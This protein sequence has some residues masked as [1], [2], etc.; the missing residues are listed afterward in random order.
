MLIER[1]LLLPEQVLNITFISKVEKIL[2]GSLDLTHHLKGV[3]NISFYFYFFPQNTAS[4]IF[5]TLLKYM[6]RLVTLFGYVLS[7]S[8]GSKNFIIS[9]SQQVLLGK[10]PVILFCL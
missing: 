2:K 10:V 4:K 7:S 3:M 5:F 6:R 9:S 1:V 8:F